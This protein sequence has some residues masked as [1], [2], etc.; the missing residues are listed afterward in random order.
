MIF[1]DMGIV[2]ICPIGISKSSVP[3]SASDIER[4]VLILG[5]LL[6]QEE[7]IKP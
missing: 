3:N 7:R 1:A 5:I 4:Y 6:A 2:L